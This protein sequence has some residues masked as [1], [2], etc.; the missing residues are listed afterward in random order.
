PSLLAALPAYRDRDYREDVAAL[1]AATASLRRIVALGDEI[2]DAQSWD[3]FLAAGNAI[4]DGTFAA[5]CAATRPEDPALLIY[6]SGS[7][8]RSKGA[9]LS[10]EGLVHC[11]RNQSDFWHAEPLRVLN[12]LPISNV[13]CIGDLFCWTMIA[14]GTTI[15]MERFEAGPLLE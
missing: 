4:D 6:T 2:A 3:S 1:A 11:L 14:G 8:G 13:F 5:A 12:N 10:H 9:L 15:F 7:T